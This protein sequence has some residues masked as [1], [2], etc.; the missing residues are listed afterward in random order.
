ML[1]DST[2]ERGVAST[3]MVIILGTPLRNSDTATTQPSTSP[4][5]P[6]ARLIAVAVVASAIV[7]A[8]SSAVAVAPNAE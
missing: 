3:G 6:C 4:Q 1:K 8:A 2:G 5:S 7:A